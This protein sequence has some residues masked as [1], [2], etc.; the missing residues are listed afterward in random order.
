MK[1]PKIHLNRDYADS[2]LFVPAMLYMHF[3]LL[4]Y[5]FFSKDYYPVVMSDEDGITDI[6][7]RYINHD[8]CYPLSQIVG[9]MVKALD[10]GKYDVS[11]VKL[12][13]PTPTRHNG[14]MKRTAKKNTRRVAQIGS[15]FFLLIIDTNRE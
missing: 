15:Y 1:L 10:S 3:P 8:M 4:K 12:L 11:K 2:I 9:Q 13:M 7:L 14:I 6:G 5:A